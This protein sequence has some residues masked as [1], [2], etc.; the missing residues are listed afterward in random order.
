MSP[1]SRFLYRG[2]FFHRVHDPVGHQS[3]NVFVRQGIVNVFAL[4]SRANNSL[5]FQQSQSLRDGRHRF[6]EYRADF[7][8]AP[9]G[10]LQQDQQPQS[11]R[12]PQGPKY[13]CRPF[14]SRPIEFRN[15][16]GMIVLVTLG[17]IVT[18]SKKALENNNCLTMQLYVIW[19]I[20][21]DSLHEI[22]GVRA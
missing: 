22:P 12:I 14:T 19:S 3:R 8:N 6:I 17:L 16:I 1:I 10:G 20:R 13:R 7:R 15:R 2:K 11:L 9:L 18:H 5:T 21:Q 4:P